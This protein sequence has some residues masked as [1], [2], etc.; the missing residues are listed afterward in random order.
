[1]LASLPDGAITRI[2]GDAATVRLDRRFP[3]LISIGMLE[4]VPD[5]LAVLANCARHAE[6][7]A[8]FIILVPRPNV[9][10]YAYQRFH[11]AHGF[12]IRLFDRTWFE[13]AA[14]Q[15]G[16]SVS[17]AVRV[18]PFSLALRLHRL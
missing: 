10:G 11:R 12:S 17:T 15:T 7:G 14:P 6:A 9:F 8:R 13:A 5:H 1:M 16:W 2:L 18:L 3:V 4:F